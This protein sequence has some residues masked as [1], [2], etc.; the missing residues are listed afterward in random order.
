[1]DSKTEGS[2]AQRANAIKKGF[3]INWMNMRDAENGKLIWESKNWD[4]TSG[5]LEARIPSEILKCRAVSREI[6][7]S[8]RELMNKFRL[9]QKILFQ[10]QPIEE[11]DF[12][13][14]FVIPNSTNTWQQ[15]IE[16]DD[17]EK[18]LPAELLSGNLVIETHFYDE[19]LVVS[20]SKVRI[21]YV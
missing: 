9:E 2:D 3:K 18:M 12:D 16:A 8:S 15:S 21:F 20:E 1:M 4:T 7:F 13:F 14:G 19:D 11:W 10:G 6:N 5:E 17:E